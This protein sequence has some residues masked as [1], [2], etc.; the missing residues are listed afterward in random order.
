[1]SELEETVIGILRNEGPTHIR[2]LI[3]RSGWSGPAINLT[4]RRL[5]A[6][7]VILPV[8]RVVVQPY[9]ESLAG[10]EDT[11]RAILEWCIV[12][13]QDGRP[14]TAA[15][16]AAGL[17]ANRWT[18]ASYCGL[19]TKLGAFYPAGTVTLSPRWVEA[20]R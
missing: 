19:L 15:E 5:R 7:G 3:K 20:Q 17:G 9:A 8:G 13:N 10:F 11:K 16:I 12:A 2:R 1:M 6:V 14:S 4:V 18:V